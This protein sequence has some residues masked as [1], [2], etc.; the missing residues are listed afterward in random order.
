MMVEVHGIHVR[1]MSTVMEVHNADE[2]MHN[3]ARTVY[4]GE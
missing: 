1:R 4:A 3:P 2:L